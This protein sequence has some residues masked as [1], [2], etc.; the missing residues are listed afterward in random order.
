MANKIILFLC[1]VAGALML[2]CFTV[3]VFADK[4]LSKEILSEY[5]P[6]LE[7][8]LSDLKFDPEDSGILKEVGSLYFHIGN[9]ARNRKSIS[10]AIKIFKKILK[11]DPNNAEIKAYLGSAYTLKARDFPLKYIASLTPL[12]FMRI[13]YVNNGVREMDAAIEL[14]PMNPIVCLIRGITCCDLPRIFRQI[15]KSTNDLALLTTWVENP[16]LNEKYQDILVDKGFTA[17]VYYQAAMAHFKNKDTKAAISLFEKVLGVA[18]DT[19]LG[20]AAKRMLDKM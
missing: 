6:L 19:P 14:E 3:Y 1:V 13:A 10:R 15:E 11:Q 8:L 18:S 7:T 4:E 9:E 2:P 5:Q 16:S 20:K 17:E 12:G